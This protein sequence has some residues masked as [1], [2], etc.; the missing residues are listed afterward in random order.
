MHS[1]LGFWRST[2]ILLNPTLIPPH[3]TVAWTG[4]R[5]ETDDT[6]NTIGAMF[7]MGF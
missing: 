3:L 4:E 6:E 5:Q 1:R 2:A 7:K